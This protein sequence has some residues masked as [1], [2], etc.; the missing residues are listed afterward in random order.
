[1]KTK[2]RPAHSG[3]QRGILKAMAK[4]AVIRVDHVNHPPSNAKTMFRLSTTGK[5]IRA[6]LVVRML[7]ES[8]IRPNADGLFGTDGP[9]QSYSLWRASEGGA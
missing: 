2:T 5:P 7:N 6:E 3:Y 8:L 1:M 4:G 9:V